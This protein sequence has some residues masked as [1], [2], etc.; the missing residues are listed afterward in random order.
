MSQL[1]NNGWTVVNPN[2]HIFAPPPTTTLQATVIKEQ[3]SWRTTI[4]F[5]INNVDYSIAPETINPRT[6]LA[7]Y[8]RNHAGLTGTK[9]G[10]NEGGCGACT[11]IL[12]YEFDGVTKHM[13]VN[14]CLRPIA[15][16]D[17]MSITTVEGIGSKKSGLHPIQSRMVE[18]NASQCGFCTPGWV[19]N[20]Y[21][22]LLNNEK[23]NINEIQDHFDGNICRCTGYRSILTAMSSFAAIDDDDEKQNDNN[24][25][26]N[27]NKSDCCGNETKCKHY[28][29]NKSIDIEDL[30]SK[31]PHKESTFPHQVPSLP[32]T[33]LCLQT[34]EC[35]WY[36]PNTLEQLIDCIQTSTTDPADIEIILGNTASGILKYYDGSIFGTKEQAT[37]KSVVVELRQVAEMHGS[38]IGTDGSI[39]IGGA[40]S[41]N[42]L[43]TLLKKTSST[44]KGH[45]QIVNH[46]NRVANNQVR[47]V[48]GF[49]GNL[50]FARKYPTFPSDCALVLTAANATLS[51]VSPIDLSN[52][53]SNKYTNNRE[54]NKKIFTTTITIQEYLNTPVDDGKPLIIV[55]MTIPSLSK[56]VLFKSFKLAIRREN[57]HATIN[58]AANV[59]E[60][61][62]IQILYHIEKIKGPLHATT[63]EEYINNLSLAE[64][65]NQPSLTNAIVKLQADLSSNNISKNSI[66]FYQCQSL[67]YKVYLSVQ[68]ESLNPKLISGIDWELPRN[69]S[70]G[71][72][73]YADPG[74]EKELPVSKGYPKVSKV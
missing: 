25:N 70:T 71:T 12:S 46:F 43:I 56:N 74:D 17:G 66:E 35:T 1:L 20:M 2:A 64:R 51:I 38:S 31:I 28:A 61:K 60:T 11:V 10:C 67:L 9:I 27:N 29:H 18:C 4:S 8:L 6:T 41:I 39:T 40:K 34:N 22:L 53:S 19:S 69:V 32:T 36:T 15:S 63:T 13:P 5:K 3:H 54:T 58:F 48:G 23:P 73:V 42:D 55:S 47:N 37:P 62:T 65:F 16:C 44:D 7:V 68:T 24:N 26:T 21:G 49:A 50:A 30:C 57:S 45:S 33:P 52:S 59:S 14:A 72:E